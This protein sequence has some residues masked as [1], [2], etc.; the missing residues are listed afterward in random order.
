MSTDILVRLFQ[1]LVTKS[2][3]Q[4][5]KEKTKNRD[6]DS[7]HC[8]SLGVTP[9]FQEWPHLGVQIMSSGL[10]LSTFFEKGSS[11][12]QQFHTVAP[13]SLCISFWEVKVPFLPK[14]CCRPLSL[15]CRKAAFLVTSGHRTGW[16]RFALPFQEGQRNA[17][18]HVWCFNFG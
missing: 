6:T 9:W 17:V 15:G 7:Y 11:L 12:L 13:L 5:I 16:L 14:Q 2:N 10:G 8:K 3:S 1:L 4:W 18:I